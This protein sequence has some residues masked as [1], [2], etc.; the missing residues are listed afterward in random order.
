MMDQTAKV[1]YEHEGNPCTLCGLDSDEQEY[2]TECMGALLADYRDL[3][4]E[5]AFAM[6]RIT[7]LEKRIRESARNQMAITGQVG[8]VISIQG[9]RVKVVPPKNPRVTWD[10][11]GLE[12]MAHF[13]PEILEYRTEKYPVPSVRIEVD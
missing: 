1:Q 10:S 12:A 8:E 2:L 6:E 13:H 9:A 11:K 3:K 7:L 5:F 4:I